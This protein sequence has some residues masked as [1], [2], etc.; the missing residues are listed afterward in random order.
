MNLNNILVVIK[1]TDSITEYMN[2]IIIAMIII[3]IIL[4]SK[5]V[6]IKNH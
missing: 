1:K 5:I 2:I 4:I 3:V 6:F